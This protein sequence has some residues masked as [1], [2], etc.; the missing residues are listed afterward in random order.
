MGLFDYHG[1]LP[2]LALLAVLVVGGLCLANVLLRGSTDRSLERFAART[3]D[4]A[5]SHHS[6]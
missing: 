3:T 4:H 2:L 6:A 1:T 5:E